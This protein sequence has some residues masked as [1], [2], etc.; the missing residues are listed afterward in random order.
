VTT[1][2]QPG[3]FLQVAVQSVTGWFGKTQRASMVIAQ[4]DGGDLA[5]LGEFADQGLLRPKIGSTDPLDRARDAWD[6]SEKGHTRGKIV[7]EI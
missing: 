5:T 1:L 4:P 6:E 2:P 3:V 7:L